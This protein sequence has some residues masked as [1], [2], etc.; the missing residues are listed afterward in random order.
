M[1]RFGDRPGVHV[2]YEERDVAAGLDRL[3]ASVDAGRGEG[4]APFAEPRLLERIR[5]VVLGEAEVRTDA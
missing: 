5:G 1:A 4:I 3:L 2:V